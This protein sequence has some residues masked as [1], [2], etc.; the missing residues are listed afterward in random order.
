[1]D[2]YLAGAI[3]AELADHQRPGLHDPLDQHAAHRRTTGIAEMPEFA[4]LLLHNAPASRTPQRIKGYPAPQA[5]CVNAVATLTYGIHAFNCA[6][7]MKKP[8]AMVAN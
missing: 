1:M 7:A 4:T 6:V 2:R 3:A 5:N 8:A